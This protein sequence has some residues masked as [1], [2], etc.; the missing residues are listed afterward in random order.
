[1]NRPTNFVAL[2]ALL[3]PLGAPA[4]PPARS[5]PPPPLELVTFSL[6]NGLAVTLQPDHS[7]PRVVVNTWFGVG[8]KDEARGRTGFAHLFEHLMFM[9]TRRVPGNQFD[10]LMESGGGSNNASTSTDKTNYFS[11][12]P[13]S[14]LPTLLWLDADRYQSLGQAMTREKLDLQRAV[15]RNERRQ[16][17]ENRPYGLAELAIP[18]AMF[19]EGHPYHHPVIG[20]HQDLEAATLEDV[21][22]F[23]DAHY[24]PANGSLVVAGDFDPAVVRPLIERLFGAIPSRP[25][26]ASPPVPPARLDGEVRRVLVDRVELPRLDLAWH[27][28]PA[29][30]PGTAEFDLL[31]LALADG[32]SSRLVRRLVLE[33]KLAESVEASLEAGELGS[34]FRVQVRCV[35]GTDLERV[36]REVLGVLEALAADGPTPAELATAQSRQ[37][38][39]VRR[40]RENLIRRADKLNEYRFYLGT[41]DGFALDLARTTGATV[42]GVRDAARQ[43]GAGRLDLRVLPKVEPGTIPDARPADLAGPRFAPPAPLTFRLASGVEVRALPL[44]GTGLFSARLLVRD[45]AL[46]VP[47]G[48]AGAAALLASLLTSGAA[49]RDAGA[50]AAAAAMVR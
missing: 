37:E 41:P 16:T 20:S 12:G 35:P 31:A 44:R 24:V 47:A 3:A 25:H 32:K 29:Y 22:G 46:A 18:E 6:P 4:A 39:E 38:L 19:P 10:M 1:M 9:G 11:V 27:A 14:L 42:T 34:Q 40:G 23:F 15:V 7:I 2:L 26:L 43:L 28:P 30:A 21:V 49:G 33:L 17:S 5:T 48:Q 50:F 45:A 8:S 13:P 36:K